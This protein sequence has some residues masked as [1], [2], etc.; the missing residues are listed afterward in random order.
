M[1]QWMKEFDAC[2]NKEFI[3]LYFMPVTMLVHELVCKYLLKVK[4]THFLENC[5]S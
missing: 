5:S 1:P 2:F 4:S 3:P